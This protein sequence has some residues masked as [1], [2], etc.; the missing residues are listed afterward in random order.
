LVLAPTATVSVLAGAARTRFI[1]FV[2]A[3]ATGQALWN[4]LSVC[5]GDAVARWTDLF[6]TF[7]GE[8]LLESTLICVVAVT[9]TQASSRLLRRRRQPAASLPQS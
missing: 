8:H 6:T 2:L 9:L 5:L 7:L 4:T 3:V 1:V